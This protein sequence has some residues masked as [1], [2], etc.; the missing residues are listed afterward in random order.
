MVTI[1][2]TKEKEGTISKGG[3][4]MEKYLSHYIEVYE[5]LNKKLK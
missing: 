4:L 1:T 5:E 3:L 2:L